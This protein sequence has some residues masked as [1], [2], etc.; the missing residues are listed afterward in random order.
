[1]KAITEFNRVSSA[2]LHPPIGKEFFIDNSSC[3][4]ANLV[5]SVGRISSEKRFWIIPQIARLTDKS[6]RFLIIGLNESPAETMRIRRLIEANDVSD[7]V[8]VETDVPREELKNIL[9]TSK[10]FLHTMIG[11]HFGISIAEAMASGCVP[12]VHNSGGPMEFVP[13]Q[14]RFDD[15]KEAAE[16]INK[17]VL[18]WSPGVA[19]EFTMRARQFS[20]EHF[21]AS[22]LRVVDSHLT[23][24]QN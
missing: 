24:L 18:E 23:K 2:V 22:F 19:E 15:V 21:C 16:K 13:K 14:Y 1:M 10:V 12:I 7:R 9:A 3:E 6:V 4:R 5:V 20:A 11:E 8:K 17:A